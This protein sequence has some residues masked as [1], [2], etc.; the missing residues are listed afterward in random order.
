MKIRIRITIAILLFAFNAPAQMVL[1]ANDPSIRYDLIKPAHTFSKVII[2][3]SAG[4]KKM[5]F[6]NES[7]IAI[8][9]QTHL[10]TFSRY[11]QVPL[12]RIGID[13]SII[14]PAPVS[15][16]FLDNPL[17]YE[18]N[19]TFK[20]VTVEVRSFI[21]GVHNNEV[22]KM[23]EG[24]FD[25]NILEDICGYLPFKKGIKYNLDCFRYESKTSKGINRY[26]IEYLFDDYLGGEKG[27]N[28][29]CKVLSFVNGYEKGYLWIDKVSKELVKE[30]ATFGTTTILLNKV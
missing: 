7:V 14:S 10:I 24:Y 3:D 13:S 1:K 23:T 6:V 28:D 8:N 4:N 18:L 2:F 12:G 26:Q 27:M 22:F 16:H 25:D 15:M 17:K 30:V 20:P 29:E 11:R 5:E 21:K 9:E 19:V